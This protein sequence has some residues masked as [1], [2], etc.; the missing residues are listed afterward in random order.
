MSFLGCLAASLAVAFAYLC[1]PN[2]RWFGRPLGRMGKVAALVFACLAIAFWIAGETTL[3][4]VVAALTALM[5]SAVVFP[6]LS[7]LL[8]PV[9]E[10]KSR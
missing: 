1:S 5:A 6:Y 3:P 4:G 10:R 2:Q 7:W 8:R 9:G